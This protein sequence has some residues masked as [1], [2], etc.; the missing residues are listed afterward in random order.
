[1]R[2]TMSNVTDG[3]LLD[4]REIS[5]TDLAAEPD[6]Q[7]TGFDLALERILSGDAQSCYNSFSSS[8]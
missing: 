7:S 3:V 2:R 8:I 1:M 4:V 6:S 5:L